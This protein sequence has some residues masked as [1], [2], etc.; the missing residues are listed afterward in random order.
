MPRGWHS[1]L[2]QIDY[3][4]QVVVRWAHF[5]DDRS[6]LRDLK[7]I[8]TPAES[9]DN[10]RTKG[11]Y[12]NSTVRQSDLSVL[13]VLVFSG[14]KTLS[15]LA[16]AEQVKPPTMTKLIQALEADSLVE[17]NPVAED[18]RSIRLKATA[19]GRRMLY[20]GRQLRVQGLTEL[21]ESLSED[22]I[23]TLSEASHLLK[24][25]ASE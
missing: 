23:T 5:K 1:R 16:R 24:T 10:Y 18:K 4:I 13:S 6:S 15:E 14:D 7:W 21:M 9:G 3:S 11:N 20:K 25:I 12:K 19:K 2:D 17:R 22:E 8:A